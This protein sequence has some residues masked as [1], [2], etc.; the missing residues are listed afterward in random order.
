MSE[1][2]KKREKVTSREARCGSSGVL[3]IYLSILSWLFKNCNKSIT[4]GLARIILMT[5]WTIPISPRPVLTDAPRRAQIISYARNIQSRDNTAS[6]HSALDTNTSKYAAHVNF[7]TRNQFYTF[8]WA[9]REGKR[10][11]LLLP[12]V[13]SLKYTSNIWS[14]WFLAAK[15]AQ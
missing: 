3:L 4:V 15:A 11:V 1:V 8:L 5:N 14:H 7:E 9:P 13:Q 12:I 6:K 10:G 2:T